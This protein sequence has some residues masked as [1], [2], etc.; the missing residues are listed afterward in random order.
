MNQILIKDITYSENHGGYWESAN[1]FLNRI[2]NNSP[3]I[4]IL[5]ELCGEVFID[6]NYPELLI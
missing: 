1:S 3:I 5:D 4:I 6:N 2:I